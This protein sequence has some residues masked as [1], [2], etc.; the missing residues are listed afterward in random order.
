MLQAIFDFVKFLLNSGLSTKKPGSSDPA[1][2][3]GSMVKKRSPCSGDSPQAWT[4]MG[5]RFGCARSHLAVEGLLLEQLLGENH[6]QAEEGYEGDAGGD[7]FHG[8][9]PELYL[10]FPIMAGSCYRLFSI[11][12]N[13]CYNSASPLRR[14]GEVR[15]LGMPPDR[16]SDCP[17]TLLDSGL[18]QRDGLRSSDFHIS[19]EAWQDQSLRRAKPE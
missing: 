11:L 17:K 14:S 12:L 16:E 19:C 5:H 10:M 9:S 15:N 6:P 3:D 7:D 13:S 8:C 18:R 1:S 4:I 2:R